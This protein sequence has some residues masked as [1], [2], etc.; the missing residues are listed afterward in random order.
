MQ[1]KITL[2]CLDDAPVLPVNYQYELSAWMYKVIENADAEFAA[3]LHQLGHQTP[4]RKSFKLFCFSQLDVPR[5]RIEGDRLH[6]ECREVSLLVGFYIDRTATEFVRGLFQEQRFS[7]GDRA[8]QVRFS[9]KTVEMCPPPLLSEG[10]PVRIRARSPLV[11]ARKRDGDRPDEYLH[12][13]DADFGKL[14]FIN[15]LDKYRAATGHDIPKFW[16]AAQF[17]FQCVG[18]EPKSKLITIKS[19]KAAETRVK[20]WMFD[21]ELNAPREL[22]ELGLLAG[23][24]KENAQGFGCGEVVVIALK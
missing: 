18:Q 6:I 12:P 23:F 4:L 16:D 2:Q 5:R 11:V 10:V 22:V 1:F 21:F 17:G 20:G 9:V 15:L 7:L 3:H 24:G 14:V 19:G 8:S 13:D